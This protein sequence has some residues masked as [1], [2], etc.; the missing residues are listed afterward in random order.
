VNTTPTVQYFG[1]S[2]LS[3]R[4]FWT[5]AALLFVAV[6][7]ATDVIPIVPLRFAPSL[8][9]LVAIVN[10]V[11]RTQTVR[12]ALLIPPGETKAVRVPR[13]SPPIPPIPVVSD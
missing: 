11:L 5:N 2:L 4:T 7:S 13:L 10:I 8:T 6:A 1:I 12:P 3:S 9:A